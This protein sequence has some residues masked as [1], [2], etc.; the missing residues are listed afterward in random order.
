MMKQLQKWT[1]LWMPISLSRYAA[2]RILSVWEIR[3]FGL[4]STRGALFKVAVIFLLLYSRWFTY[5]YTFSVENENHCDFVKLREMLIR[6]NM[7][8]LRE[9][10]HVRHY[11]IYRRLRLEQASPFHTRIRVCEWTLNELLYFQMGFSDVDSD[12]KPQ[13]FQQT[14]EHKRQLLRMELQQKEDEMRQQF[15]IRVKEKETELKE[16]EKEVNVRELVL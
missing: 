3:W 14:Y 6:T 1:F 8:D 11:E 10:T 15:V 9:T 16:A 4:V 13:S 5:E 2:R 12:N 7:E